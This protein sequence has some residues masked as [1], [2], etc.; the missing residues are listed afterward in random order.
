MIRRLPLAPA[1]VAIF[2]ALAVAAVAAQA[3]RSD[4]SASSAQLALASPKTRIAQ[5]KPNE[6]LIQL[7]NAKPGQIAKASTRLTVTGAPATVTVR[8]TNLR[9]VAGPNGGR[10]ITSG[11]LLVAINCETHCPGTGVTYLGA[12]SHMNTRSLGRWAAGTSR[13]YTVR[14]WM[15]RGGIPPSNMSGDNLFQGST[16]R[17][18]LLWTATTG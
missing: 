6:A 11:A 12:L 13:T 15:R 3:W 9:D 14:V 17:F 8:P 5:T 1:L 4:P 16:A 10:L 18:G 7:P 2:L